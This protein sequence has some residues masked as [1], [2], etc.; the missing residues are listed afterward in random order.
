MSRALRACL[1]VPCE[2]R[3]MAHN[4]TGPPRRSSDQLPEEKSPVATPAS[5][6]APLP[7]ATGDDPEE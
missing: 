7:R 5:I 3:Q 1:G 4:E 6:A 2:T